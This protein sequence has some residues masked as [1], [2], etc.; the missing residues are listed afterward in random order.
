[1]LHPSPPLA[2]ILYSIS[3]ACLYSK[4]DTKTSRTVE[5]FLLCGL[6]WRCCDER[7]QQQKGLWIMKHMR[8]S[9]PRTERGETYTKRK[10]W[11]ESQLSWCDTNET[12]IRR[13]HAEGDGWNVNFIRPKWERPFNSSTSAQLC[14]ATYWNRRGNLQLYL[15]ENTKKEE[16]LFMHLPEDS[17]LPHSSDSGWLRD[18]CAKPG[19]LP[20]F[21]NLLVLPKALLHAHHICACGEHYGMG[22]QGFKLFS[23]FILIIYTQSGIHNTF[24]KRPDML[25]HVR[26]HFNF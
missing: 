26:K 18:L 11:L 10:G 3:C 17:S 13:R 2:H 21:S 1:M 25:M 4:H 19:R 5:E 20:S 15:K 9:P 23:W 16:N 14:V 22:T 24:W 7:T 8:P 12:D 6:T